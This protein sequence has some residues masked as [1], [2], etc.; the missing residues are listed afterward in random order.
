MATLAADTVRKYEASNS[1]TFN[2]L[3]VIAADIIYEGAAVGLAA[4]GARPLVAI[5][6]FVG[7]AVRK[8]DNSAGAAAD[9]NVRTRRSGAV[10]I[11]V[12]GVTGVGDLSKQVYASDDDTFTLTALNNSK[13]GRIIRFVTGTTCIVA[14]S[15]QET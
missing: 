3:P 5:D 2:D 14:F 4:T 6:K 10:Q 8:A 13:I 11:P 15:D 9:I 1:E 7:F 12:V